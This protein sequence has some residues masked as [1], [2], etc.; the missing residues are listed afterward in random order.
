ME[1]DKSL[2]PTPQ[3]YW[4]EMGR[5]GRKLVEEF[6]PIEPNENVVVTADTMSD[7]RVVEETVKAIHAAGAIPTLVVHPI[8]EEATSD[9]PAP[10]AAALQVADAWIEMNGGPY[11]LYSDSWKKAMEAGVRYFAHFGDVDSS[12]RMIG[13]VDYALLDSLASKLVELSIKATEM[14][15]TSASG[16]DLR[17]KVD[18]SRSGGH[19]MKAGE[20]MLE[21]LTGEGTTQIP[22]GQCD[23]GDLPGSHE[24]T[25]V[26]DGALY[27]PAEIGI[28]REPVR[29]EIS[30]GRITKITGG[31]EARVF[32]KW[33]ATW[34]HSGMYEIAHCSY[35]LNPGVKRV[36]GEIAHDERVFG[37]M[38]FGIGAAWANAPSH[39]D[40]VVLAPSIWADDVQLEEEGRY[41]HPELVK[42]CRQLGVEGY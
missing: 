27:P 1:L 42:L 39:T 38:E 12:V 4:I 33:L 10:V 21:D 13:Q 35:G 22:P 40:G 5:V 41:V 29:L 17:V 9:P 28:L 31:H 32:E 8:T 24:G 36:K 30:K 18:P 25:L 23:F 37:C 11:L 20:G 16:T 26:F 14:R 6:F 15:I 3:W 19:V 2:E 34:D 7:W